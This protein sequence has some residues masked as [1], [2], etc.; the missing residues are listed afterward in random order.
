MISKRIPASILLLAS[1]FALAPSLTFAQTSIALS[2]YGAFGG[3]TNSNGTEQSPAN[4]AGGI[5][6]LRH[7]SN[8]DPRFRS[9]LFL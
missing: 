1:T 8:P 2:G 9:H 7:I 3:A 5:F 4:Q 6:E